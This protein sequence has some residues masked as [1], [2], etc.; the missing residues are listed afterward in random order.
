MAAAAEE[1]LRW[2][3][4]ALGALGFLLLGAAASG[5]VVARRRPPLPPDERLEAELQEMIAEQR[6]RQIEPA[7]RR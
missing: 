7:E 4:L 6:A 3:V 1:G 5:L 2:Y